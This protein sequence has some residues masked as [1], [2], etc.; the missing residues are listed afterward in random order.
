MHLVSTR[1]ICK[2]EEVD[3]GVSDNHHRQQSGRVVSPV[4]AEHKPWRK[5]NRLAGCKVCD[6]EQVSKQKRT[7]VKQ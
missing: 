4:S 6:G 5:P 1:S 7:D 2:G 3:G